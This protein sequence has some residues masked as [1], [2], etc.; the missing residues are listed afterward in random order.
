[1][2]LEELPMTRVGFCGLGQMGLP[3][4]RRLIDAGYDLQVWNR[5]ASKAKSLSG[6]TATASPRSVAQDAEVII[7]MLA[8]PEA[9]QQVIAGPDGVA[10]AIA[11]GATLIEMSTIGPQAVH[12]LR[13]ALPSGSTMLDA[14]VLGSVPQATDGELKVFT[15]GDARL[16]ERWRELLETFGTI[17][18][19]GELGQGAAM[20]LVVNSTLGALMT[21]LGEAV[22]LAT[23]L[24]LDREKMLDILAE[25]PIATTA[26]SKRSNILSR[27]Y[28]PN[29]KLGLAAKDIRLV[30]EAASKAGIELKVAKAAGQWLDEADASGL[31]T[32]D[33]SAVI[34]QI[35]GEAPERG[36]N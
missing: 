14:P 27:T 11:P 24:G 7:T 2:H 13:A 28:K 20:K 33:Y 10:S 22:A 6:A 23:A 4:A 15:G 9:A 3:M 21:A 30:R 34:A 16:V 36:E 8:T 5:T 29:F 35:L 18:H 1:M 32:L 25:S 31:S 17:W 12:E 26:K 19:M